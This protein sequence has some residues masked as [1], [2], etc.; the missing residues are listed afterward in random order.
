MQTSIIQTNAF[1][2]F[3]IT[4]KQNTYAGEGPLTRST[5]QGSID[6]T[7]AE[8]Q[9]LYHDSYL[10][11]SN[12]IG[13]EAV[14]YAG[15][16]IWG[17]NYYGTMIVDKSPEGFNK[18]L[19]SALLSVPQEMPF[20]GPEEMINGDFCYSCSVDGAIN[21]FSGKEFVFYKGQKIY[22]LTFH[23]GELNTVQNPF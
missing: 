7:Y 19:K 10:G 3:L 11:S 6:L 15:S 23:G 16:A 2:E 13:E 22:Q 9:F 20:R 21:W 8:G 17:M 4:A 5:R 1:Y 12:F 18:F 14:W